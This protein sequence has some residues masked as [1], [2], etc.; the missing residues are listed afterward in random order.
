MGVL[1][2]R[3]ENE[4]P[5]KEWLYVGY[6]RPVLREDLQ[7]A[8]M[9]LDVPVLIQVIVTGDTLPIAVGIVHMPDVPQPI[10]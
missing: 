8:S 5:I 3:P 4:Q 10:A 9:H 6:H 7:Q 2:I 1:L